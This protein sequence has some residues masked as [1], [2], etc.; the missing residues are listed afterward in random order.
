MG[1]VSPGDSHSPASGSRAPGLNTE[2]KPAGSV[3]RGH[4]ASMSSGI[5]LAQQASAP[6]FNSDF[7][8]T[9]AT[10]IPVLFVTLAV[11][12]GTLETLLH[13]ADSVLRYEQK[14]EKGTY[15]EQYVGALAGMAGAVAQLIVYAI[16]VFGCGGEIT[17]INALSSSGVGSNAHAFVYLAVVILT[18]AAAIIP[19]LA[20][21]KSFA[22]SEREDLRRTWQD[23]RRT[24]EQVR[25]SRAAVPAQGAQEP[26][27]NQA[28]RAPGATEDVAAAQDEDQKPR[29]EGH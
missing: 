16:L 8:V 9:V 17:A 29:P 11:E 4:A 27:G 10:V 26:E 2:N 3:P 5:S 6:A 20:L 24:W 15:R 18:I 28:A 25:G 13:G 21:L 1:F 14:A 19:G 22:S 23:I 7:Y 12:R